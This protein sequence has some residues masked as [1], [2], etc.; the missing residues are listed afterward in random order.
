MIFLFVRVAGST[1]CAHC[2]ST[3]QALASVLGVPHAHEKTEDFASQLTYLGI[4]LDSVQGT[5]CLH[6]DKLSS[7]R[8]LLHQVSNK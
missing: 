6:D 2:L 5:S 8:D 7:V 3:F 1:N 4:L